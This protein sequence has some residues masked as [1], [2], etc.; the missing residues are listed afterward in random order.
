MIRESYNALEGQRGRRD[1]SL[2][3]YRYRAPICIV[4]ETGF[5]E[6]AVLDRV[7]AARLSKRDSSP[8]RAA[9]EELSR[10]PLDRLG[11]SLLDFALRCS[12]KEI[13]A[14]LRAELAAVD[15]RLSDRPRDNAATVRLGLAVLDQVLGTAL[16]KAAVDRAVIDGALGETGRGRKSAV[17]QILEAMS[18]MC[19]YVEEER[20]DDGGDICDWKRYTYTDHLEPGI[21]YRI[22]DTRLSLYVAG[23]YPIFL[24]W[25]KTHGFAGD[26]LP[27]ASF[28]EQLKRQPYLI[29]KKVVRV[30]RRS[31]NCFV[32]DLTVMVAHGIELAYEW[33][34]WSDPMPG[35]D[36]LRL[37]AQW[38]GSGCSSEHAPK[39]GPA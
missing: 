11:R 34:E 38:C 32:L 14:T 18:V 31:C 26:L 19:E 33:A 13:T 35:D 25:A 9:F 36:C 12:A 6:P 20:R 23:A 3:T 1:Q 2:Q 17:S 16:D 8:H 30:G 39:V 7:V 10:M 27:E 4:G 21:H 37:N 29:E 24:R 22:D 15:A 28:K 5:V